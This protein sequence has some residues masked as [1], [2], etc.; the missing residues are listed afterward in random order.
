MVTPRPFGIAP[1]IESGR[2]AINK[3][4]YLRY[5]TLADAD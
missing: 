2:M 5:A 3:L 4:S 1:S